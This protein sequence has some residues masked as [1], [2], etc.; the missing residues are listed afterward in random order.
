MQI[1]R[2]SKDWGSGGPSLRREADGESGPRDLSPRS[3]CTAVSVHG[4]SGSRGT[5]VMPGVLV[6]PGVCPQAEEM[7]QR[8][9]WPHLSLES[10]APLEIPLQPGSSLHLPG[11]S[12]LMW[13]RVLRLPRTFPQEK[14]EQRPSCVIPALCRV[15]GESSLFIAKADGFQTCG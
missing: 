2:S 5:W 8:K 4:R 14:G 13:E 6:E 7:F 10:S 9:Q 12:V 1:V 15:Q 3:L 11:V